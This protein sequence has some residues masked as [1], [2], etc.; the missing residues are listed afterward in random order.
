MINRRQLLKNAGLLGLFGA[1][2]GFKSIAENNNNKKRVLRFAHLTDVHIE[3][4]LNASAGLAKCLHH[5]QSQK[6]QPAFI[7]SGGDSIFDALH[8]PKDRVELQWGLWQD[9]FKQDN[10]LPI[11]YCIGNHDCWG[12][13]QTDDPLYGK[14]YAMEKMG[15]SIPYRSFDK[16]GW[17]FIV[18]DSIQ[19]KTD[20]SWYIC[21]LDEAQ[22]DW[23]QKD[24]SSIPSTTPIVIVSHAP[25]VSAATVITDNKFKEG[26]GY[27]IGQGAM[28]MDSPRIVALFDKYPNIKFCLSG[29]IHLYEQIVYNGITYIC[30]GAVSGNWWKGIRYK[31]DNGYALINLYDDGSF[32]NEYITYGWNV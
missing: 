19:P 7:M 32:D 18:L 6:D 9:I 4:E 20:G 13:G 3:P 29:H 16:A 31:T 2:F 27:V 15:L 23:L 1:G 10:S 11:E 30:N 25:I 22:F 12:L 28:H 17:H 5:L 21:M 24:L 14:K 26:E 8:Q